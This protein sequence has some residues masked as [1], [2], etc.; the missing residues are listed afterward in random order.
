MYSTPEIITGP[1]VS[2]LGPRGTY[3]EEAVLQRFGPNVGLRPEKSIFAAVYSMHTDADHAVIPLENS[4][5]GLVRESQEVLEME[6]YPELEIIGEEIL[7]IN[8]ALLTQRDVQLKDIRII[9]GH[10]QALAQ[11]K[12]SLALSFPSVDLALAA[13]NTAAVDK[14]IQRQDAA[15]IA[16]PRAAQ[17][18]GLKVVEKNMSDHLG[19]ATRFVILGAHAAEPTG[20]DKTSIICKPLDKA[21]GLHAMIGPLSD[22]D[23]SMTSIHSRPSREGGHAMYL[24]IE[25]HVAD[26][27][28]S[29]AIEEMERRAASVKILGSYPVAELLQ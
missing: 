23:I 5:T 14:V 19:N 17:K 8:H 18:T 22:R 13:S 16:S 4:T 26:E 21:G 28:V 27:P 3:S 12:E 11:C 24:E 6:R 25:G 1:E 10:G 2:Y 29:Q 20:N 15:L 9:Y 7:T